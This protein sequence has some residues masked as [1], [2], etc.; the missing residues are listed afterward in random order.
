MVW[1]KKG[2]GLIYKR[3]KMSVKSK[4]SPKS[5]KKSK[6]SDS[7]VH[8]LFEVNPWNYALFMILMHYF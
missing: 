2:T 4:R 3:F 5:M 8:I 1:K 7:R 6:W